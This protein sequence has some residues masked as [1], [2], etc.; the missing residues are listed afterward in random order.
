[1]MQPMFLSFETEY[2]LLKFI[3]ENNVYEYDL[4]D[5]NLGQS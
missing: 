5:D 4:V 1:M 2:K 3:E